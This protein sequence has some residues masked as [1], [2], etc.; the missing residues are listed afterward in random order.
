MPDM[1][2]DN[3]KPTQLDADEIRKLAREEIALRDSYLEF[4]QEQIGKVHGLYKYWFSLVSVGIAVISAVAIFCSYKSAADMRAEMRA[5]MVAQHVIMKDQTDEMKHQV[6]SELAR[7]KEE[8]NELRNNVETVKNEA[9]AAQN[10]VKE[11][12]DSVHTEILKRTNKEFSTHE[13]KE[14]MRSVATEKVK[15]TVIQEI[16]PIIFTVTQATEALADNRPAF[17][18]LQQIKLGKL[19]E[20]T[21]PDT[22]KLAEFITNVIIRD[23]EYIPNKHQ[24]NFMTDNPLAKTITPEIFKTMMS[25]KSLQD[26]KDALDA[27][28]HNDRRILPTLVITIKDE[29][30]INILYLAVNRF[31]ELTNQSFKFYQADEL[32]DW[33]DKNKK[34]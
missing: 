5:D 26:R 22:Q 13:L 25:S 30:S 32:Q 8:M 6:E 1:T 34:H 24:L 19:P 18:Y 20:S 17:D 15:D 11:S 12:L 29:S 16:E 9:Q 10:K 21:N 2:S 28:P 31:D 23:K 33:W 3:Q 4:A 27:Y 14:L 7:D